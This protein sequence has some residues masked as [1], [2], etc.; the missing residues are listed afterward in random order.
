M[1]GVK[2][3]GEEVLLLEAAVLLL[4]SEGVEQE[5]RGQGHQQVFLGAHAQGPAKIVF[6]LKIHLY[7]T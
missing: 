4:E 2:E 1:E 5:V 7:L 3:G 6:F